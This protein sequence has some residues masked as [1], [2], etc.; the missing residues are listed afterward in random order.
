MKRP[1][2]TTLGDID[3]LVQLKKMVE[4]KNEVPRTEG[5]STLF[6]GKVE[7]DDEGYYQFIPSPS[8]TNNVKREKK[9]LP[10][11][12]RITWD[13]V[14]NFLY[15]KKK[16]IDLYDNEL[17]V[18]VDKCNKLKE[19]LEEERRLRKEAEKKLANAKTEDAFVKRLV[20]KTK[21]KF[22]NKLI[23]AGSVAEALDYAG[24]DEEA[25]DLREW[26]NTKKN[27]QHQPVLPVIQNPHQVIMQQNVKT[28][29]D[30]VHAGGTG[31]VYNDKN[32]K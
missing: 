8:L 2:D 29:I 3:A 10:N 1:C 11:K 31:A 27:P 18:Y 12:S 17:G 14:I 21:K 6:Q 30:T 7:T 20:A 9:P 4:D 23:G 26:I 13:E 15:R 19:Q 5:A 28:Q 32:Q 24:R 25:D 22:I 16:D